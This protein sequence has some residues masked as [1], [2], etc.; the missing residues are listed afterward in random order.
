MRSGEKYRMTRKDRIWFA[1]AHTLLP[2]LMLMAGYHLTRY[3]G[4]FVDYLGVDRRGTAVAIL[5]QL[6]SAKIS[7]HWII[8]AAA[9]VLH[10]LLQWFIYRRTGKRLLY[11]LLWIP[12]FIIGFAGCFLLTYVNDIRTLDLQHVLVRLLQ[13]GV[14]EEL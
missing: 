2:G 10:G 12:F 3:M 5:S 13:N 1:A 4:N 8:P 7:L 11:R 9:S 14:L 6:E